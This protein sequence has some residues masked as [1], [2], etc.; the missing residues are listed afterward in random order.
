MLYVEKDKKTLLEY[1]VLVQGFL[2]CNVDYYQNN[3]NKEM[4]KREDVNFMIC[5]CH[6]VISTRVQWQSIFVSNFHFVNPTLTGYSPGMLCTR[7]LLFKL[8]L[9]IV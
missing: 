7:T 4:K 8:S 3:Q 5:F 6:S 2:L 1:L 9:N